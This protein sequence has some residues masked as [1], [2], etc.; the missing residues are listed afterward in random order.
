MA[1]QFNIDFDPADDTTGFQSRL[2]YEPYHSQPVLS[3]VW[4]TWDTLDPAQGNGTG[5]W[6]L[7]RQA[8][9]NTSASCPQSAT[10]TWDEVLAAFPAMRVHPDAG[11]VLFKAGGGWAG[12]DG[13]VDGFAIGLEGRPLRVFNCEN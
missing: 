10:S 13:N 1:L 9:P 5:N 6:W 12:F 11:A 7:V 8:A 3:E 4:Q 2:V